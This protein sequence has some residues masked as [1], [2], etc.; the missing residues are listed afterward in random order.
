[1]ATI[2]QTFTTV[3]STNWTVPNNAAIVSL[4]VVGGGGSGG[5]GRAAGGGGDG[6]QGGRVEQYSNVSVTPGST[7]LIVVGAGGA[8]VAADNNGNAGTQSFV[9]TG[10]DA[11]YR[12]TGGAGGIVRVN[13]QGQGGSGSA[14]T[15]TAG[16]NPTGGNGGNG[17]QFRGASYG[18]GGGG[19]CATFNRNSPFPIR[20]GESP[21]PGTP[22]AGD[23]ASDSIGAFA[24]EANSGR[25]GGG[26]RSSGETTIRSALPVAE[27]NPE[28]T[29]ITRAASEGAAGGSGVVIVTYEEASYE[30]S[31]FRD[32]PTVSGT[33]TSQIGFSESGTVTIRL[34]TT[35]VANG[36]SVPFTIGGVGITAADFS[37]ATLAGSFTVSSTDSGITG[38]ASVT[39][40]LSSDVTLEN[41]ET[42]TLALNNGQASLNFNIGDFSKPALTDVEGI[43]IRVSDYNNLRTKVNDLLG[44]GTGATGYGQSVRSTPVDQDSR[45]RIIQWDNLRYDIFNIWKHQFG[46]LPTISDARNLLDPEGNNAGGIIKAS[47]T[48]APYDQYD[49]FANILIANR[50]G[51]HSSQAITHNGP[52][53]ST[54]WIKTYTG[55]WT[56]RLSC[57]VTVTWPTVNAA[58]FFFNSGGEIRFNSIRAAGATTTQNTSWSTLLTSAGTLSFGGQLPNPGLAPANGQN[59]YRLT[60]SLN[61]WATKTASSPY[62][63]NTYN[64]KAN[65]PDAAGAV[66]NITFLV[67]WI[68]GH[69]S[70]NGSPD[71]VDG[72]VSLA[73]TTLEASGNFEP[74]G[75]GT[76]T[77][78][79]PTI[80]LSDITVG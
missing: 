27:P 34:K 8:A 53:P 60:G 37:P 28:P 54:P 73:V 25:G 9:F 50:F 49:N 79:S 70:I 46:T 77:V 21:G 17:F 58:R 66:R 32:N 30:L 24:G 13:Q 10:G 65:T 52:D 57:T 62:G 76:F 22:S 14:G 68:D 3:G 67:E 15:G 38:T 44:V 61:T 6:G 78:T 69:I 43:I 12:A 5:G 47:S 35:N 1:M 31:L 45:V 18:A 63:A 19:G 33:Q 7:I 11:A 40:T 56:T 80:T 39:L 75:T 74:A 2:T 72:T 20:G 29:W 26:G 55:S 64:I 41:T 51:I 23:G 16:S 59:Y 48:T 42:A 4:F 71:I 36:T